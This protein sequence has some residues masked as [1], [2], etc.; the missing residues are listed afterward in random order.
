MLYYF[1]CVAFLSLALAHPTFHK[2][3]L[4]ISHRVP[5]V[6]LAALCSHSPPSFTYL[7]A[8]VLLDTGSS[9]FW[10]ADNKCSSC[11]HTNSFCPHITDSEQSVAYYKG[12]IRGSYSFMKVC[13][14]RIKYFCVHSASQM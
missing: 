13:D 6:S 12:S 7:D 5:Y 8:L 1:I 10:L 14:R 9:L 11:P 3:P 2:T 4:L